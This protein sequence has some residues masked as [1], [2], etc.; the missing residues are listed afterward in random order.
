MASTSTNILLTGASG[1]LG[2]HL[3]DHFIQNPPA[4]ALTYK[5][6][7]LYHK[8]EHFAT[9]MEAY[10]DYADCPSNLQIIP[11]LCNLMDFDNRLILNDEHD[12]FDVCIHTAAL[13]SPRACQQDPE[14]AKAINV[15]MNFLKATKDI[16]NM[17]VLSTD[18]VYDGRLSFYKEDATTTTTNPPPRNVYA[19]TKVQLEQ[20][21]KELRAALPT[22]TA[23]LRSSIILGPK[24]PIAPE[25]AHD[26]FLHFCAS[27]Q[28]QETDLWSNE[29]R[30]VV[31]VGHVCRVIHA[32]MTEPSLDYFQVYNMGGPLRVNRY[33]MGL[34]VFQHFGWESEGILL[35]AEQT[36]TT[37]PLDISMD[38]T[39]LREFINV[40][41]RPKTLEELVAHVF[42]K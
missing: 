12:K 34:A 16:E 41:H 23:I 15:P 7:A 5:I 39:K 32:L 2:Q 37:V 28:N 20:A 42:P 3:L 18:Q 40:A 30:S 29:Y 6:T 25:D 22:K 27:R 38:S 26:T 35:P 14:K 8:S 11:K 9:A 10:A 33:D 1:Y 24:A 31:S 19:Q 4:A 36:A 17:I 13:S 21:L